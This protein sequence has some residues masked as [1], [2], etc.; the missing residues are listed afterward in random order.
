ML[1]WKLS[2]SAATKFENALNE[3]LISYF[4][5]YFI[6]FIKVGIFLFY[7]NF[8]NK[9]VGILPFFLRIW[10]PTLWLDLLKELEWCPFCRYHWMYSATAYNNAY[11]DTGLF[12]IHASSP[13]EYVRDMVEV[14]VKEMVA[15]A[16]NISDHE[17]RV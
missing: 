2:N 5:L 3:Y 6:N 14:I 12:C 4:Y 17:L 1:K 7:F 15:M 13:P 9:N 10:I 16:G 8:F 11:T